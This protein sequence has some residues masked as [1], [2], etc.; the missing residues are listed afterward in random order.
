MAH[1]GYPLYYDGRNALPRYLTAPMGQAY[2]GAP[3]HPSAPG[4]SQ[5]SARPGAAPMY[6]AVG[7][8]YP[9]GAAFATRGRARALQ[10]ARSGADYVR[11]GGSREGYL[12]GPDYPSTEE[13][14]RTAENPP[15]DAFILP[16]DQ[17]VRAGHRNGRGQ[18]LDVKELLKKDAFYAPQDACDDHFEKN[19]PCPAGIYGVSDQYI[20]L[21]TFYKV[22]TSRPD[23]GM[24]AWNFMV[25]GVTG[26]QVIGVKDKIDTVIEIQIGNFC[27]PLPPDIPYVSNPG[28]VLTPGLPVLTPN[29]GPPFPAPPTVIDGPLTQLPYCG[30]FT[31]ELKECSLQSISDGGRVRH[32]FEF[33]VIPT[34]T[35]DRLLALPLE[36]FETYIFTD[37]IKSVD[38]LTLFFRNPDALVGFPQDCFQGVQAV[39]ALGQL[40]QFNMPGNNL[41][42]TNRI[43]IKG[44]ASAD[45]TINNWVNRAQGQLVGTGGFVAGTSFRL[46]PDVSVAS[47][48]L[49]V[50]DPIPTT[51]STSICIAKNRMRIPLRLRRVVDRLTQYIAP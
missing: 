4:K 51:A 12:P 41:A 48:G 23:Q 46:D 19:R 50:G 21:D 9:T 49:A 34:E 10:A 11:G 17:G 13:W 39:V 27:T 31:I 36:G 22:E 47:L 1:N 8:A 32:H 29:N 3:Y 45:P 16:D 28:P 5:A 7:P 44:F 43:F 6:Q 30:R 14:E 15:D 2:A 18:M 26:N 37:P 33:G 38:G 42:V 40:L 25:Q 20:V 35:N 24:F